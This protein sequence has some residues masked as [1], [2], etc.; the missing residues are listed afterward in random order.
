MQGRVIPKGRRWRWKGV[1]K[2]E[3]QEIGAGGAVLPLQQGSGELGRGMCPPAGCGAACSR[4][5]HA[6]GTV[7]VPN[8]GDAACCSIA[9]VTSAQF[10]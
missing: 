9:S 7:R 3:V 4:S 1:E 6:E 5:G 8:V 10:A 2:V